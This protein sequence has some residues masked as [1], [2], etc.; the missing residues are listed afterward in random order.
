MEKR[1]TI[2]EDE[3]RYADTRK[4]MELFREAEGL[5]QKGAHQEAIEK[6][7]QSFAL[8]ETNW[9]A[10]NNAA[11]IYMNALKQP[12]EAEPLFLQA[13][14]LSHSIQVA[15]NLELC[16]QAIGRGQKRK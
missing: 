6:F 2:C 11:S 3:K 15:R 16:R 9:P 5:R 14:E 8:D 7:L 1:L 12:A 10:L 13:L 4:A